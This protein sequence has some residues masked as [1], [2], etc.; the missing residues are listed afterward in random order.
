MNYRVVIRRES[1]SLEECDGGP[2]GPL[3][4]VAL[5]RKTYDAIAPA[6][7]QAIRHRREKATGKRG[8]WRNPVQLDRHE[9]KEALLL[10]WGAEAATPEQLPA[11]VA[12][13]RG[14]APEERWW[15]VTQADATRGSAT[16]HPERG[17]RAAI[18]HIL[19]ENGT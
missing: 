7:E 4:R 6:L 2:L 10:F 9:G 19:T 17:W 11:V 5:P 15:L 1:V 3:V 18:V 14:L 12:N 13:W 16:Y 8:S